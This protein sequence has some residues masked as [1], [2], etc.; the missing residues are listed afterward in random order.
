M[1]DCLPWPQRDS[2]T[3]GTKTGG[4]IQQ[5][6]D[7]RLNCHFTF[8]MWA[9][10]TTPHHACTPTCLWYCYPLPWI[11]QL[12]VICV[13]SS[14]NVCF[15]GHDYKFTFCS[16]ISAF[17]YISWFWSMYPTLAVCALITGYW[18][19]FH[20]LLAVP[21]ISHPKLCLF[22]LRPHPSGLTARPTAPTAP[23]SPTAAADAGGCSPGECTVLCET[24][25]TRLH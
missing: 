11:I 20:L 10:L 22:C 13:T 4:K 5:A 15:I 18:K 21:E 23:A 2:W 1:E 25:P 9:G 3:V 6:E 16:S 17:I 14:Y 19:L 8:K 7:R 24:R 12:S